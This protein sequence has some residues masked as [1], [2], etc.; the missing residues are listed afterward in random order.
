MTL[1]DLVAPVPDRLRP[2]ERPRRPGVVRADPAA[3]GGRRAGRRGCGGS[4]RRTARSWSTSPTGRSRTRTPPAPGPFPRRVR[5]RRCCPTPTVPGW[6]TR[7]TTSSC[8]AGPAAGPARSSSTGCCGRPGRPAGDGR[9]HRAHR[10]ARRCPCRPADRSDLA[11]EGG[12]L[13]RRSWRH[14][15]RHDVRF[16]DS[17][18]DVVL[19]SVLRR[20]R[21]RLDPWWSAGCR[22]GPSSPSLPSRPRRV[23]PDSIPLNVGWP[24]LP[25]SP[26][27]ACWPDGA[28]HARSST[29]PT[30]APATSSACAVPGRRSRVEFLPRCCTTSPR[31]TRRPRS[32]GAR[33]DAAGLRTHGF[34]PA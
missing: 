18:L 26:T 5:Q 23:S 7:A 12:R 19:R 24:G 33:G 20:P 25:R 4:A 11:D 30:A 27:C 32:S 17:P 8:R 22:V 6:S 10:P 3:G 1:E 2:R 15:R 13:L 21:R 31:S 16:V 29:T 14:G 34:H 28:R 9:G